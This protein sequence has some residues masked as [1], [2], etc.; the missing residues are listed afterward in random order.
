MEREASVDLFRGTVVILFLFLNA[1]FSF[2]PENEIPFIFRHNN[3]EM[4]LPGDFVAAF[5]TFIIG[6]SLALS[7]ARRKLKGESIL[8]SIKV[9][10]KRFIL[11]IL[12]GF[13]LDSLFYFQDHGLVWGVLQTLGIA[14]LISLPL[15]ALRNR[16]RIAIALLVLALYGILMIQSQVFLDEVTHSRNGG[17]FG[18]ISYGAITIFGVVA[19][20]MLINKKKFFQT[21]LSTGMILILLSIAISAFMP[22]SKVLV[23]P[24]YA[25]ISSGAAFFMLALF[26]YLDER[27]KT[28]NEM[29]IAYGRNSLLAWILQYPLI[30]YPL[31]YLGYGILN[32][33]EGTIVAF[34]F[35]AIVWLLIA[36]AGKKGFRLRL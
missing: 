30:F 14:G 36:F 8:E 19:G 9:Y 20:E 1:W 2:T 31:V 18:A 26:K 15:L 17:P 12:L 16:N 35:T 32:L 22:Y 28:T 23:S 11:L 29:L 21:A 10:V 3:P 6:V 4:L 7:F 13:F 33:L 34:I 5:F 24:S 25:L 27:Y